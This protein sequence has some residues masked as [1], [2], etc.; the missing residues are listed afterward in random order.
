MEK[1]IWKDIIL[2]TIEYEDYQISSLQRIRNVKTNTIL[3]GNEH[4]QVGL[5]KNSIATMYHRIALYR[6]VFDTLTVMYYVENVETY[7]SIS[8]LRKLEWLDVPNYV[9]YYQIC[10]LGITRH[11]TREIY[12]YSAGSKGGDYRRVRLFKEK[13]KEK[14]FSVHRLVNDLFNEKKTNSIYSQVNH[15]KG[16]KKD[17][18]HTQLEA[19]SPKENSQHYVDN[20]KNNK[21]IISYK[22]IFKRYEFTQEDYAL[23][24]WKTAILYNINNELITFPS[25]EVSN[26]GRI[27]NIVSNKLLVGSI[28]DEG[29]I[30]VGLKSNINKLIYTRLHR[31]IA[32]TWFGKPDEY[33]NIVDHINI[34]SDTNKSDNRISNLRWVSIMENNLHTL[35]NKIKI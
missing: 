11:I 33:K 24:E 22:D 21:E 5:Y 18:R 19:V 6:R 34:N 28:N 32:S 2:D 17:N 12:T 13:E 27:R 15:I 1:E 14:S 4:D 8:E 25:H 30:E 35:N 16:F 20:L 7:I 29:Y 10:N 23:E 26:I 31:I 3:L 9:G